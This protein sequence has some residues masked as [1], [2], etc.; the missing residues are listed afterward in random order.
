METLRRSMVWTA[1]FALIA[2]AT[3]N[4]LSVIGRH[5]GLPFKGSIEL[6]QAAI[7]IAGALSLIAATAARSHARVRL[8]LDRLAPGPRN[9]VQRGCTL[10][11]IV[12]YLALLTGSVWL[13]IDLWDAQEVS[14]IIGVPWRVMRLFLNL[15]L[16]A[17]LILLVRQLFWRRR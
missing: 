14:E 7:L 10:L 1:G 12:F 6:V 2:A 15:A 8:V 16:V 4:F 3:I 5:V 17:I 11:A 9:L 13:A